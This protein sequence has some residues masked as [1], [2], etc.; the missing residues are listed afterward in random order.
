MDITHY[1]SNHFLT[2]IDCGPPV[3]QF[4]NHWHS[5]TRQAFFNSYH[6]PFMNE[7]HWRK[8]WLTMTLSSAASKYSSF[9]VKGGGQLWLWCTYVPSDNGITERSHC[10]IKRIAVRKQCTIVEATYWYNAM[11]KDGVSPVTAPTNPIYMYQVRTKGTDVVQSPDDEEV[12]A[13]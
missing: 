9:C 8:F 7:V 10:S 12:C 5:K 2:L 6:P 1:G 3:L 13:P 4:G 11:S